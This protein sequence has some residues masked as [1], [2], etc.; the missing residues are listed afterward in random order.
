MKAFVVF[1][2][3]AVLL[4]ASG[5]T[6]APGADGGAGNATVAGTVGMGETISFTLPC[7]PTTGYSWRVE[8]IDDDSFGA[9]P[10]YSEFVEYLGYEFQEGEQCSASP[11]GE[12]MVGCGGECILTFK[13]LKAGTA[14]VPVVYCRPWECSATTLESRTLTITVS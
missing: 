9:N 6:Q 2:A 4:A 10:I 7:N 13:A 5:C 12:P 3:L 1:A 8:A 11:A 14:N